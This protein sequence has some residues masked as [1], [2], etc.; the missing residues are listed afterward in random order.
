MTARPSKA[1][2]LCVISKNPWAMSFANTRKPLVN[3]SVAV[4]ASPSWAERI[5]APF[6][7]VRYQ[8]PA[9]SFRHVQRFEYAG[10]G[11]EY[12][13]SLMKFQRWA[14]FMGLKYI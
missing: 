8:Y 13:L 6:G 5:N 14:N 7:L 10:F 4:I 3:F 1:K 12:G 9:A 2:P 11:N